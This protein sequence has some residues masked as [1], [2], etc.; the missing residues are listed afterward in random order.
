[1]ST[2]MPT[3]VVVPS[4]HAGEEGDTTGCIVSEPV[5]DVGAPIQAS[6]SSSS[7]SPPPPPPPLVPNTDAEQ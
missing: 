1:M 7:S 2:T 4:P 3:Y 5:A 6:S